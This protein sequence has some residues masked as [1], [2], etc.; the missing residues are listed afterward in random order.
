MAERDDLARSGEQA[1]VLDVALRADERPCV[2]D[3]NIHLP[4]APRKLRRDD[5][6]HGRA[7]RVP[8]FGNGQPEFRRSFPIHVDAELRLGVIQVA[9]H[10]HHARDGFDSLD[11]L[12]PQ[13]VQ[14]VQILSPDAQADVAPVVGVPDVQPPG[15]AT[16]E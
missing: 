6:V 1:Q 15:H 7:D 9:V 10:V 14:S 3:A 4:V 5:A 13:L 11:D 2:S 12:I 16:C 8:H